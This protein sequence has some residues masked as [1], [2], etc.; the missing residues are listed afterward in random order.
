MSK[1]SSRF[2]TQKGGTSF[3]WPG[4]PGTMA[5]RGF[6]AEPPSPGAAAAA[7]GVGAKV[8]TT[9]INNLVKKD[10]GR[11]RAQLDQH[12]DKP[13]LAL[14]EDNEAGCMEDDRNDR[15]TEQL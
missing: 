14:R 9:P 5:S 8:F 1:K 15:V 2:C 4:F 10:M 12:R 6:F 7:G 13:K 11:D 3:E